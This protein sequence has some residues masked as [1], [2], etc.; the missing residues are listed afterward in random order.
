MTDIVKQETGVVQN[1]TDDQKLEAQTIQH[2]LEVT[3]DEIQERQDG[4]EKNFAQLGTDLLKV[5]QQKFWILYGEYRSYNAW[6][7]S[8]E[9]RIRKGR[10]QL[11]AVKT[12]AETLLPYA[13]EEDLVEMGVSKASALAS[14]VKK[15]GKPPSDKL[16]N[17]AKDDKVTVEKLGELIAESYGARDEGEKGTWYSLGGVFYN[18]EEKAEFLRA[19]AVACK[20]DPVLPYVIEK[21]EDATAPQKKEIL[22]RMSSTLL[23]EYESQVEKGTA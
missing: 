14:A 15:S 16:L 20:I 21:W 8:V 9:P 4:L 22:W 2:R 7:K 11:Y 1:W 17:E 23:A 6:L 10:S 13:G 18:P 19:V 5:Q 3:L 12:I